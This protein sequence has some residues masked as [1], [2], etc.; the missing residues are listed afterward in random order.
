MSSKYDNL[1]RIKRPSP[2]GTTIFV[3]LRVL[4]PFL[5]YG[6]LARHLAE[7][8]FK[9]HDIF[10]MPGTTS[11]IIF[12][13]P[14]KHLILFSM[15]VGSAFKSLY[16]ILYI[17]NEEMPPRNAIKISLFE[18]FLNSINSI[19][20][21]TALSTFFTPSIFQNRSSISPISKL[22]AVLYVIALAIEMISETQRKWFKDDPRNAGKVF[23]KGLFGLAR[24][25][26]YA[27]YVLRRTACALVSGGWIWAMSVGGLFLMD[28]MNRGIPVLDEYCSSQ[29]TVQWEVYRSSVPYKLIPWVY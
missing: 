8:L 22:G 24:H 1:S 11:I 18:F 19:L 16:W 23:I 15:V 10:S 4:D 2:L 20:G 12:N 25:I 29:Y 26:N 21:F 3:G 28:F 5:Q 9:A 27:G 13:L 14:L 17:S 6:I 7:P